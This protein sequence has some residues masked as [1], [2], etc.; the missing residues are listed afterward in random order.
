MCLFASSGHAIVKSPDLSIKPVAGS[1]S[2]AKRA[3]AEGDFAKV[4][5]IC[6]PL[7]EQGVSEAQFILG[8]IYEAGIGVPQNY[9]EAVK[10]YRRAAEQG[11]TKAQSKLG[12]MYDIGIGV[13]Q[14][15]TEVIKWWRLAAEQGDAFAQCNLAAKY[16]HGKVVPRDFKE[17]VK[18]YRL[19]AEQGNIFGQEKLAWKY[20]LG[21]GVTQDDVL[22][23]M[24]LD[25]A[26]S[27]D[28]TPGRKMAIHQ[29]I[30]QRDAI[31]RRMTADQIAKARE[32]AR[33]CTAN[34][35]KGC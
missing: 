15:Y 8:S 32:L 19:A 17:A 14:D 25:I 27:N 3:Y 29:R 10:W 4:E 16:D 35:F 23:Y 13:P 2:E 12:A 21:E 22:A 5:K 33:Q 1:L 20:L 34:K 9:T 28:F 30:Q 18:W 6:E 24:W 26:A 7:A 31:A 11:N